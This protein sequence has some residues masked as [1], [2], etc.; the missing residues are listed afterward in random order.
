[1]SFSGNFDIIYF[2]IKISLI[3]IKCN[4]IM[5]YLI[6]FMEIFIYI[7][8]YYLNSIIMD[9]NLIIY[10]DIMNNFLHSYFKYSHLIKTIMVF[11]TFYINNLGHCNI[12]MNIIFIMIINF[13]YNNNSGFRFKIFNIFM[14]FIHLKV[15]IIFHK[16]Y[17]IYNTLK[18]ILK[19]INYYKNNLFINF[20]IMLEIFI[21]YKGKFSFNK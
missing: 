11:C 19:F 2:Q 10:L 15:T 20:F 13:Y 16:H 18:G 21:I 5:F 7:K 3:S 4:S 12:L 9:I 1:M 6:F 14:K 8:H 17:L